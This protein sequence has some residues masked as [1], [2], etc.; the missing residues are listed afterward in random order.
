MH[1]FLHFFRVFPW[2]YSYG[3]WAILNWTKKQ[4]HLVFYGL[5][6]RVLWKNL[7][8]PLYGMS[9]FYERLISI[10]V[11]FGHVILLSFFACSGAIFFYS[12]FFAYL[13]IPFALLL[14]TYNPLISVFT[15]ITLLTIYFFGRKSTL[16]PISKQI[17][18]AK[19]N[20]IPYMGKELK[21]VW[22][23]NKKSPIEILCLQILKTRTGEEFFKRLGSSSPNFSHFNFHHQRQSVI[24]QALKYAW[25]LNSTHIDIIHVIAAIHKLRTVKDSFWKQFEIENGDIDNI[26]Q[27]YS[28]K[29]FLKKHQGNWAEL[30]MF[31]NKFGINRGLSSPLSKSVNEFSSRLKNHR[32]ASEI[33]PLIGR[34]EVYQKIFNSYKHKGDAILLVGP[35]GSGKSRIVEQFSEHLE[36]FQVPSYLQDMVLLELDIGRILSGDKNNAANEEGK[37]LVRILDE[38]SNAS[39]IILYIDN[40]IGLGRNRPLLLS[41]LTKYIEKKSI[42]LITTSTPEDYHQFRN[43]SPTYIRHFTTVMLEELQDAHTHEILKFQ[44][45]NYEKKYNM[46]ISYKCFQSII[47]ISKKYHIDYLYAKSL[48]AKSI[49]IGKYKDWTK[50]SDHSPV[51]V[52]I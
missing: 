34:Y 19:K 46:C 48:E 10:L 23:K 52:E 15:Y 25:K 21:K 18:K 14:Y 5:S 26:L 30:S 41:I 9:K 35:S 49:T 32:A 8:K 22:K 16:P 43:N 40:I 42:R 29:N 3:A 6:I 7:T 11:R 24:K 4:V 1:F 20:Y 31:Q 39:H 13:S 50:L 45:L 44:A 38:A 36:S 28:D 33:I 47:N 12:I 27:I 17:K 2:W 37:N 51:V